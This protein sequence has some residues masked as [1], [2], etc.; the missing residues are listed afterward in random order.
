MTTTAR[1]TLDKATREYVVTGAPPTAARGA[2]IQ[3]EIVP[4]RMEVFLTGQRITT[5]IVKGKTIRTES[6]L[7]KAR[8]A[9]KAPVGATRTVAYGV[10]DHRAGEVPAWIETILTAQ[11]KLTWA[12]DADTETLHV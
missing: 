3:F 10:L 7:A 2:V 9:R 4:T 1:L 6:E 11:E 5:V 12:I 8:K